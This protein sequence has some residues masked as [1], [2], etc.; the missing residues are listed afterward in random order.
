[1]KLKK[2]EEKCSLAKLKIVKRANFDGVACVVADGFSNGASE[3]PTAHYRTIYALGPSVDDLK[4]MQSIYHDFG[5][6]LGK[7]T[8]QNERVN[9]ALI[10]AKQAAETLKDGGIFKTY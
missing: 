3:F 7:S 8:L 4:I 10:Q 9:D 1:M 2:F 6:D 5:K